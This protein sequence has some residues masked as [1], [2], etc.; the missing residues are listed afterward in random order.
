MGAIWQKAVRVGVRKLKGVPYMPAFIASAATMGGCS[1]LR[2]FSSKTPIPQ[3]GKT[4]LLLLPLLL[5]LTRVSRG[6]LS[7]LQYTY[8]SWVF[9]K[10]GQRLRKDLAGSIKYTCLE[11]SP[12]GH[13]GTGV[14]TRLSHGSNLG[15]PQHSGGLGLIASPYGP[16]FFSG[17]GGILDV[18]VSTWE[19]AG[20]CTHNCITSTMF[21]DLSIQRRLSTASSFPELAPGLSK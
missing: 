6:R 13:W 4:L 21:V 9:L 17:G 11:L 16:D 15:G 3:V 1:L 20:K 7:C 18:K 8:V 14:R 5:Q 19:A 2:P 10:Q 12:R